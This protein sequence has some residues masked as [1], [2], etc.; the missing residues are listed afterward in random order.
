MNMTYKTLEDNLKQAKNGLLITRAICRSCLFIGMA[1]LIIAGIVP[2]FGISINSAEVGYCLA[3]SM[4][5]VAIGI[6]GEISRA[7]EYYESKTKN[8]QE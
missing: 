5:M 1:L 2:F 3:V 6:G 4:L 7:K 8:I